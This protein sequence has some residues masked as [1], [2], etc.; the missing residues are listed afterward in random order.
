MLRA[1]SASFIYEF[2]GSIN[3]SMKGTSLVFSHKGD[4][5]MTLKNLNEEYR[6][7][8]VDSCVRGLVVGIPEIVSLGEMKIICNNEISS[9][10]KFRTPM[11]Y[12]NTKYTVTGNIRSKGKTYYFIKGWYDKTI[13]SRCVS[14]GNEAVLFEAKDGFMP[15]YYNMTI[16]SLQ[17]NYLDHEM[18]KTL[19]CTDSRFRPDIRAIE[20]GQVN[21]AQEN[22]EIL[23]NRQRI[24]R[25]EG[26]SLVPKF[27]SFDGAKWE[28]NG[29]YHNF[30]R[31]EQHKLFDL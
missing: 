17:L 23:E 30:K 10:I 1:E 3:A 28:W 6:W 25:N 8:K 31:D 16:F 19:L 27:F 21:L 5:K 24:R 15:E 29:A 14:T 20:C 26:R 12:N 18:E 4:C 7:R 2:E 22:K 11:W 9:L 13:L